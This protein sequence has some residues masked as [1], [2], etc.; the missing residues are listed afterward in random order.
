M[1][2]DR[3]FKK[4]VIDQIVSDLQQRATIIHEDASITTED[5]LIQM[6]VIWNLFKVLENYDENVYVLEEY[7]QK[8]E[9]RKRLMQCY[10]KDKEVEK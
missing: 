2:K 9:E 1:K 4:E 5:R 7:R 8:K 6:D 3:N 10:K